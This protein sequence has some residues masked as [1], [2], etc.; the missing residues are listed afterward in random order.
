MSM[1]KWKNYQDVF[2]AAVIWVGFFLKVNVRELIASINIFITITPA[3]AIS[4]K[5]FAD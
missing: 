2:A 1:P 5:L 3:L 4:V